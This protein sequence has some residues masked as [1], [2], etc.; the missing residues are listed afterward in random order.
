[1]RRACWPVAIV[2][3]LS[4]LTQVAAEPL[5]VAK[6]R[7][8]ARLY[9]GPSKAIVCLSAREPVQLSGEYGVHVSW[10]PAAQRDREIEL[11]SKA[12]HFPVPVRVEVPL[13]REAR[14]LKVEVGAC[15]ANDY[16][17]SVELNLELRKAAIESTVDTIDCKP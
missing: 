8:S 15:V 7:V 16:C 17:D 11:Y 14:M 10:S 3:A 13:P 6:D 5:V 4:A 12:E 1:M 2:L 9:R